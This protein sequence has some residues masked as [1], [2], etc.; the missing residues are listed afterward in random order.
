MAQARDLQHT[1]E[2]MRDSLQ[3]TLRETGQIKQAA[4]EEEILSGV[5]N[6]EKS[7]NNAL[8]AFRRTEGLLRSA[9]SKTKARR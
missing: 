8:L 2:M 9:G 7:C 3:E 5:A 4:I 6:I 1:L